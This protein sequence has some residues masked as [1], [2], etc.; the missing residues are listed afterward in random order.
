VTV[1]ERRHVLFVVGRWSR[2][3]ASDV[4]ESGSRAWGFPSP[5][6]DYEWMQSPI[7]YRA[8][9][10]FISDSLALAERVAHRGLVAS[11]YLHVAET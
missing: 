2:R 4:V 9:P 6:S 11:H 10:R 3:R 7:V 1:A 8:D 5:D